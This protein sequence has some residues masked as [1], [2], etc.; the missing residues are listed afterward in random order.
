[1]T[2]VHPQWTAVGR[3]GFFLIVFAARSA[4]KPGVALPGV[5]SPDRRQLATN[6]PILVESPGI[7]PGNP[8]G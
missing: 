6:I 5:T 3:V 7:A 2:T 1:M 8:E 4:Q